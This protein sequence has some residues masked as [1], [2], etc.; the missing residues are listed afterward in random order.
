M[1][2]QQASL[3]A[4]KAAKEGDQTAFGL[5]LEPLLAQAYRLA[6]GL[7]H[8]HQAA[9]DAV[10]E[11]ALN[12]WRKLSQLR[13]GSEMR[14]WFLAIVANECRTVRRSR[15]WSVSRVVM[16]EPT[17]EAPDEQI[18][19]GLAIRQALRAMDADKRLVLV[20]HWYLDLPI[21]EI[22][23][24]TGLSVRGAETRLLRA[25]NELRKRMEANRGRR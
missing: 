18:V 4:I 1:A 12:A 23:A 2:T 6:A 10:Q 19:T 7:L 25:T 14:P 17:T 15:W 3:I 22:A 21:G 13:E 20:L 9:E 16:P 8:D 5:L 11:A 24:V